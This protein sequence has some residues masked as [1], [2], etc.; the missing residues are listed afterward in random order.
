MQDSGLPKGGDDEMWGI[1]AAVIFLACSVSLVLLLSAP[2]WMRFLAAL[3]GHVSSGL[4]EVDRETN[5][6]RVHP[7]EDK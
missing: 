1:E 6:D 2:W 4:D 5:P 7:T 3:A